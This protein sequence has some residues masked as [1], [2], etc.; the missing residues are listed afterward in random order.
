MP[1]L[2]QPGAALGVVAA[3]ADAA[4]ALDGA[5]VRAGVHA[6]LEGAKEGG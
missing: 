4:G 1:D 5:D 6:N 3:G 2:Q